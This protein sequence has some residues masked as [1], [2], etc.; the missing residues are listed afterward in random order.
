M[1]FAL[2]LDDGAWARGAPAEDTLALARRA[3]AGGIDSLFLTEDP[4][5]WDAFAVLGAIAQQTDRIRLGTGVANPYHRYPNLLAASVATLDR[6]A[7]GRVVLGLGRGQPEWYER[8]LG[9]PR[10]RPLRRLQDTILL[11]SQW[12]RSGTASIDG[13]FQIEHWIRKFRPAGHI[14][15]YIAAAGPKA[16]ELA[17]RLA[18]G[19]YFNML[20]T[21]DYLVGAIQQVKTVATAAGRD[22][23]E[24]AFVAHPGVWVTDDPAR[25]LRLRKRFVANVLALPGMDVLLQNPE[26]DVPAIMREVRSAMKI[27]EILARG[28]AFRDLQNEGDIEA[29]VDAIPDA[30][31]ER[32]S[33]VGSLPFVRQRIDDF[34]AV[35][36]TDLI[37]A[38]NG[39]PKDADGIRELIANLQAPRV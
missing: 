5:G 15:I 28:G 20:T 8:A 12:E 16:L 9:M 19:V 38:T 35:G 36:V 17:G 27:D 22:P 26:L 13:E 11:L 7:P 14:P 25:V 4:D 3:D 30:L 34:A 24:L 29:A 31:V 33:A 2:S 37:F 1:R 23:S 10:G 32:G 18:D 21:P 6:L 39:L